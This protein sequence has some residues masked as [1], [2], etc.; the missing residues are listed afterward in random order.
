MNGRTSLFTDESEYPSRYKFT[1]YKKII[2]VALMAFGFLW[3]V[4]GLSIFAKD[5]LFMSNAVETKGTVIGYREHCRLHGNTSYSIQYSYL[6][7]NGGEHVHF[8]ASAS[9]PPEYPI[10][11]EIKVYYSKKDFNKAIYESRTVAV[12][13]LVFCI[14]GFAL[15]VAGF[16]LYLFGKKVRRNVCF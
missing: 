1:N 4:S 16:A 2:A 10:G 3:F 9:Y 6:D 12:L 14:V 7:E 11:T 8:G 13:A 5:K 15:V